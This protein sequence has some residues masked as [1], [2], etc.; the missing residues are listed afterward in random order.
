LEETSTI[1]PNLEASTNS[2]SSAEELK[3]AL[4][5]VN[6]VLVDDKRGQYFYT[7]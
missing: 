7:A 6:K 2:Q 3:G 1:P 4:S 5:A